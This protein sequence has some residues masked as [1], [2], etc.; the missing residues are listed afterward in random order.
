VIITD[1]GARFRVTLRLQDVAV[2][3]EP[4]TDIATFM[5]WW[6]E[7]ATGYDLRSHPL[8]QDYGIAK[9]LLSQH[10]LDRVTAVGVMFWSRHS[11]PLIEGEYDKHMVL[12]ASKY[13]QA[14]KDYDTTE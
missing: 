9:R 4:R 1:K 10:G 13:D 6:K 11:D 8:S 7:K 12:F 3:T 14:E 2:T 5:T